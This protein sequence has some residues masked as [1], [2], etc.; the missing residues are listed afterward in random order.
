[1]KS[2]SLPGVVRQFLP[3]LPD[4][5][6]RPP[7]TLLDI[8]PYVL[9]VYIH[10]ILVLIPGTR[11]LRLSL[12]PFTIFLAWHAIVNSDFALAMS[13]KLTGW[14]FRPER[15]RHLNFGYAIA[16]LVL[17][18]R[19]IQW[20]F[21]PGHYRKYDLPQE[22]ED[23]PLLE[24]PRRI[25]T[26]PV[27]ALELM[28]N[29]RGQGWSWT[30]RPFPAAQARLNTPSIAAQCL[31]LLSALVILDAA[32]YSIQLLVPGVN[33]PDGGTIFDPFLPPLARYT[34]SSI[35]TILSAFVIFGGINA[36]YLSI[37]VPARLALR[38]PAWRWQTLFHD[39]WFSTSV[40]RFWGKGWHQ[41]FRPIFI[42]VGAV[43]GQKLLGTPGA[44]MGAFAASAILH[45]GGMWA[46]GHGCEFR[47]VSGFFL[48]GGV[49]MVLEAGWGRWT[50]RPVGGLSGWVWT[51]SW[52]LS[53]GNL[54]VDAWARRGLVASDI[55]PETWR[56]GKMLLDL[57]R[58]ALT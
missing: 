57:V 16:V 52:T 15:L 28:L 29:Q 14:G 34:R 44:V 32:H 54:M 43:P 6:L 8:A 2:T 37:V 48:A 36:M 27:D 10:A 47:S 25:T 30:R 5:S 35:V 31:H 22:G 18:A 39:P 26:V 33:D 49:G 24:R 45:D 42:A 56:P 38:Q 50:G 46:M 1:M 4:A 3:E 41:L 12:L 40:T 9:V 11:T 23:T 20:T 51:M 58:G 13:P 17:A 55:F 53:W 19:S 7:T 21:V